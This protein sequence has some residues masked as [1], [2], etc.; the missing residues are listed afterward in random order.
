MAI[1]KSQ[2]YAS[3][4]QSCNELRGGMDPSQYK[5]YIL[6]LLFMK[7]VSDKAANNP[8]ISVPDGGGF[9][10]MV[11]VKNNKDIGEKINI[12]IR[13]FGKENDL[14]DV[15][16]EVDFEDE[17]KLGSGKEMQERLT[18]LVGI[19]EGLD[20]HANRVEGDDLLGDAY[21]YLMR[22]F[23]TESGK[24]KGQFYTPA[25]VSRIIANIIGIGPNTTRNHTIYDPTCGSGSLLL[26]AADKAPNG[27]SVYGQEKD[28]A[29]HALARM[30]MV[31]HNNPTAN[32][33]PGDTLSS[34]N[35]TKQNGNGLRTF[36]FAVANPPF[37]YKS[38]TTGLNPE[39]DEYSRFEYGIPPAKNGDYAFLL[40]FIA[41]LKRT[42]KGAIILPH[43]VLFRGNREK[44]IRKE[45]IELGFIKGI[46]GLPANLFYGT[47][48]RACILVIDKENAQG[49]N[50]IF[51]VDASKGFLKDGNKNRL[52]AQDIHKIV[53][54]FNEQHEVEGY[55][56]I[57]PKDEIAAP[58]NDYNLNIP[59]YIDSS[60]PEDM[61][62]LHAHLNG[63]IPNSD[64]DAL[65]DY[66]QVFP[67][68]RNLL[69][70]G[71][72][73]PGYSE[74]NIE[75][76]QLR[77]AILTHSD[78]EAYEH[79]INTVFQAWREAH[80]TFLA[81]IETNTRPREVI[82]RLSEYL[83]ERFTDVP[84]LNRYDVYQALMDYWDKT[85]QDD[86]YLIT[87]N[88]W[89]QAAQPRSPEKKLKET[90]DL[91]IKKEKYKMDLIPPSLIIARYFAAKQDA[92][93]ILKAEQAAAVQALEEFVEEH[94]DEE[95]ALIGLEGKS[96]IPVGNVQ[97][98]VMEHKEAILN[99]YPP[100]TPQYIR[101]KAI[102]KTTFAN[103]AWTQ[104]TENE[105]S[106]LKD[107]D[108]SQ[109]PDENG[110]F[111]ELGVLHEC[112]QLLKA[113]KQ[114]T[115]ARNQALNDLHL[116]V[117]KK[118]SEL[119]EAEVKTL[120]VEKKWIP[121][122]QSAIEG[123]VHRLIQ[124][125]TG[126]VKELE[127][128]YAQPLPELEHKVA[129]CSARVKE[130]MKKIGMI[131]HKE[132]TMESLLTGKTR[133]PGFSGAWETKQL[134]EIASF[135]KG[136]SLFTKTDMSLDGKR[137]CIHYGELFTTYGECISEVL[138][139]TDREET[140]FLSESNDILMPASDVTPNGL[141]TAS[142]I[143]ESDI[144][145]GGD[146]LVIRVPEEI[147]NGVFLAYVI[148]I[149]RNP[150]MQLV[151]GTTVY[152]LYGRDMANFE[153]DLP[154]VQEQ[155]AI[156]RVLSDM[157][158]EITAL[159]QRRDKARAIKQGMMQQLLTRQVRLVKSE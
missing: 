83:L 1:K 50:D 37:S 133:L 49:R 153:F 33:K 65:D 147:L 135:F 2:I 95:G 120:V 104:D 141:A 24:S 35:F 9:A 55:S 109:N 81:S 26:K 101:A 40:H 84:L 73:S 100:G 110:L 3:L 126:R 46:I 64:I 38:W 155:N 152:H 94:T 20:L 99:I 47:G 93:E 105:D 15:F 12:I 60:E 25:E 145:L 118:Y 31:L 140:F 137:R 127:E 11:A 129:V 53:S 18:E 116:S 6:T 80:E 58:D 125:L 68:L 157:D 90:A 74:V 148:K 124:G 78:F 150:V 51:M 34:P 122:I 146:I 91:T 138:H 27:I 23:A 39:Y 87:T 107:V 54:V 143:S 43:G 75:T 106:L 88:G 114:A 21:E 56:R 36:D 14:A 136:S 102:K 89:V 5:D 113:K 82:R 7:Y 154:C 29:T 142:C 79:Q 48:I 16:D 13:K 98:R 62:D 10:D 28:N 111:E 132:I 67:T 86:A 96:G 103:K 45:L 8:L 85:M 156:V 134:G 32:I 112:L 151:T 130:H 123:E 72:G 22:N 128:R 139:G 159:E 144:I 131:G 121:D 70:R 115:D 4:L 69:F 149:N 17:P 71:N 61:H 63:G 97:N 158:A 108:M 57:V 19:F 76:H 117:L 41:S 42:G 52:R 44:D 66:W 59:R 92:I 119:N 77:A 30:N